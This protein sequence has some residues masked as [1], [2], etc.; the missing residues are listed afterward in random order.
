MDR[1]TQ[2]QET[3]TDRWLQTKTSESHPHTYARTSW[4]KIEWHLKPASSD[5]ILW[6]EKLLETL[7]PQKG[8]PSSQD[9]V[10]NT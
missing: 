8:M 4:W 5:G 6:I 7:F 3:Q 1:H 10:R 9:N 2:I